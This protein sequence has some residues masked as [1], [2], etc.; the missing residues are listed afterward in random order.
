MNSLDI[1]DI[2]KHIPHR[3]PF[4]LID[5]VIDYTPGKSL[6]ALKNVT[7]NEPFFAGHFPQYPIMPGVL[8]I[9]A[10]AQAAGILI[11]KTNET[12]PGKD[13]WF[14]LAGIDDARFKRVV[15]PGDQ[16]TLKVELERMLRDVWKFKCVALVDNQLAC[17][18]TII[19]A[20]GAV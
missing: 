10:L 6:V 17:S 3:Y 18:A 4:L 15:Q 14:Y 13:N 1:R 16:L 12:L 8:I 7:V 2:L 19:N 9:E 11:F 5:K 20:K